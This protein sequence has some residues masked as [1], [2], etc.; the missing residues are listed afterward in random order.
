MVPVGANLGK[1]GIVPLIV[2]R[3][4]AVG[5]FEEVD[6]LRFGLSLVDE[7]QV[8]G[9]R[10][11]LVAPRWTGPAFGAFAPLAATST[12]AAPSATT[13][14]V[15]GLALFVGA[16][17]VAPF[18]IAE[19]FVAAVCV[20]RR[21]CFVEFARFSWALA[22]RRLTGRG[23]RRRI[24]ISPASA[25]AAATAATSTRLAFAIGRLGGGAFLREFDVGD[26]R[27]LV[28]F[29]DEPEMIVALFRARFDLAPRGT[30]GRSLSSFGPPPGLMPAAIIAAARPLALPG[31]AIPVTGPLVAPPGRFRRRR[32]NGRCFVMCADRPGWFDSRP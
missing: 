32:R 31:P 21:L 18:F 17:F 19:R 6:R 28:Y 27:N 30:L 13:R 22:F 8:V 11:A 1:I 16:W 10:D 9:F 15:I 25:S 20:N 24:A 2:P 29:L 4:I 12:T 5:R 14:A 3:L 7:F 26:V 23:A